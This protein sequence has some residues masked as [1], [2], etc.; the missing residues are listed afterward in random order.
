MRSFNQRLD[1]KMSR[2]STDHPTNQVDSKKL[3]LTIC[4]FDSNPLTSSEI[5]KEDSQNVYSFA[6]LKHDVDRPSETHPKGTVVD[7]VEHNFERAKD[8]I[9]QASSIGSQLIIFPEYFLTGLVDGKV[10]LVIDE[11]G[12]RSILDRFRGLA[13]SYQIDI[14]TGTIVEGVDTPSTPIQKLSNTCYYIDKLGEVVGRYRKKNLWYLTPGTDD[15]HVFVSNGVRVGLLICWDLS[16]PEAFRE[17]MR[18][19]VELIVIPSYWTLEKGSNS[20]IN[21]YDQDGKHES[22]LIDSMI[23]S[24]SLENRCFLAF[25]NCAGKIQDGFIGRSSVH[26]TLLGD[27]IRLDGPDE[28]S[29]TVDIDFKVLNDVEEIYKIKRD[30]LRKNF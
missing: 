19:G 12:V 1:G 28:A 4:Q 26:V 11:L 21:S 3:R 17:L 10:R 16:W 14:V 24:R 6:G 9:I 22:G 27:L 2:G 7:L 13:K 18:E 23:N 25:V 5:E 8:M 29:E 15:N 30:Y 20:L